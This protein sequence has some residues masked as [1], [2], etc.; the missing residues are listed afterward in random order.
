MPA[1]AQRFFAVIVT[2][3][4]AAA[5]L[6]WRDSFCHH[7][8]NAIYRWYW[9]GLLRESSGYYGDFDAWLA[10]WR[11]GRPHLL[12]FGILIGFYA[13]IVGGCY[14]FRLRR[15][16]GFV[17]AGAAYAFLLIVP[18]ATELIVWDYDTFLRGIAFD[19]ISMDLFPLGLWFSGDYTIFLYAFLLIFFTAAA[20]IT[21]RHATAPTQVAS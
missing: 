21:F 5:Y 1:R 2:V 17:L 18:I 9:S 19:S 14:F 3:A 10:G 8:N 20:T 7:F 13:L 11:S 12:E 15:L 16:G 6:P 4:V